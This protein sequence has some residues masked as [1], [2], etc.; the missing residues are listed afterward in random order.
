M[1]PALVSHPW[2]FAL[3]AAL[4]VFVCAMAIFRKARFLFFVLSMVLASAILV[5]DYFL[6]GGIEELSLLGLGSF[7]LTIGLYLVD[8]ARRKTP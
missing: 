6:G 8:K 7:L 3:I 2:I 1:E 4:V 5:I